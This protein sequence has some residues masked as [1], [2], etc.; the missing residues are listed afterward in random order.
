M[1]GWLGK[2]YL[3]RTPLIFTPAAGTMADSNSCLPDRRV[4]EKFFRSQHRPLLITPPRFAIAV[5][6]M[7]VK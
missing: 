3:P 4:L 5:L 6:S 7:P 2:Y 1:L